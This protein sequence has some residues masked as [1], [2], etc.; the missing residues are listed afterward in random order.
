MA[1]HSMKFCH[2]PLFNGSGQYVGDD[3]FFFDPNAMIFIPRTILYLSSDANP[4][5]EPQLEVV[6]L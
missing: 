5:I 3:M 1:R 4:C 2:R 6:D